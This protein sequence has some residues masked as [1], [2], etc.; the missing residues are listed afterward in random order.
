MIFRHRNSGAPV[1]GAPFFLLL[2]GPLDHKE[3]GKEQKRDH[4]TQS[5]SEA[6]ASV[7]W[8]PVSKHERIWI[9]HWRD[10]WTAVITSAEVRAMISH[11]GRMHR[12][13]SMH[14]HSRT[15]K[16]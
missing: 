1:K 2:L 12:A 16:R 8:S 10:Y 9:V 6:V 15:T 5:A 14:A 3:K 7:I 13:M 4:N 11:M